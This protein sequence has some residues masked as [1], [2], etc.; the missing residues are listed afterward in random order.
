M[1]KTI[2][3]TY[4]YLYNYRHTIKQRVQHNADLCWTALA[5]YSMARE[6]TWSAKQCR[7]RCDILESSDG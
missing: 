3:Y 4:I 6:L 2:L 7:A 5:Y 1:Y